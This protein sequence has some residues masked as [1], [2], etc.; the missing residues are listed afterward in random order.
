MFQKKKTSPK[1]SLYIFLAIDLI[2]LFVFNKKEKK[3]LLSQFTILNTHTT[4]DLIIQEQH[5]TSPYH[6]ILECI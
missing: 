2:F 6:V 3:G 1:C 5:F 4:N